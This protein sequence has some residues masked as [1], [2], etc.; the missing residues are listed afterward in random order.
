MLQ[1]DAKLDIGVDI[2]AQKGR[3]RTGNSGEGLH[4]TTS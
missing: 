3:G 1:F 4:V 2:C